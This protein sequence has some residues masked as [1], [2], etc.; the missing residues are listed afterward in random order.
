MTYL[1][2]KNTLFPVT[3]HNAF[4]VKNY[5]TYLQIQPRTEHTTTFTFHVLAYNSY[6]TY[7][8]SEPLKVVVTEIEIRNFDIAEY[9]T[10]KAE[11]EEQEELEE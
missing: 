8:F 9:L 2:T 10:E 1:L 6:G 3:K 5:N 4:K 11:I 7:N